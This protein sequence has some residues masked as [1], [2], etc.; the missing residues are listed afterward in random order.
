MGLRPVTMGLRPVTM[1]PGSGHNGV[2][3]GTHIH[4]Y[5]HT[6]MHTHTKIPK[7]PGSFIVFFFC[8]VFLDMFVF[9]LDFNTI[10]Q[11]VQ[12]TKSA[13]IVTHIQKYPNP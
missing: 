2:A 8:F 4:A 1:K 13:K 12:K 10:F 6:H 5:T 7:H 9:V 11:F 3:S